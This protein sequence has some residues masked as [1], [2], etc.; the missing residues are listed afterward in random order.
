MTIIKC[1]SY[2]ESVISFDTPA[3]R[4]VSEIKIGWNLGNSFDVISGFH[5]NNPTLSQLE[6]EWDNPVTTKENITAIKNAGFNAIRIPVTWHKVIDDNFIIWPDWMAR[7]TEV[8]DY[9]V[10]NDMYIILNTHHDEEI[11]KFTN[12]DVEKSLIVFRKIWE[13]I[14][15]NFKDYDEKLIFEALNEPRTKGNS[16]EWEGGNARERSNINRHYQVFVDVVRASGGYNRKRMLMITPHGA[17]PVPAALRGFTLPNDPEPGRLIVSIHSYQPENFA[18]PVDEMPWATATTWSKNKRSDTYP[19]TAPIDFIYKTFVS[20]GIPV[21][22][23]EFGAGN[24]NNITARA[25]WAE[26]YVSYARSKN[27]P[28]FLWDMGQESQSSIL[29]RSNSTFLFPEY[30]QALLRGAGVSGNPSLPVS[31]TVTFTLNPVNDGWLYP[32]RDRLIFNG[33]KIERGKTY[34]F[35]YSF[36]SNVDIDQLHV[37]FIDCNTTTK[38]AWYE[39]S[40]QIKIEENILANTIRN[41]S[42]EITAIR[43]ATNVMPDANR[44]YFRAGTGTASAPILTFTTFEIKSR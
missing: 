43:T 38:W 25:E 23:G 13:Q 28:C 36:T 40:D 37:F 6:T 24:K 26:F 32:Y 12:A 39:L 9:A 30:V 16:V 33:G 34:T 17:K 1:V 3:V 18:F 19:I 20:K 8:V 35:T 15:D 42:V 22:I 29:N 7:V 5:I 2:K 14:A 10:D 4:L 27:I 41:G 31:D 21:I 11:F 44:I